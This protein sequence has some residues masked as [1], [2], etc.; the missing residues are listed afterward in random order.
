MILRS[1]VNNMSNFGGVFQEVR[2]MFIKFKFSSLLLTQMIICHHTL[3]SEWLAN[4]KQKDKRASYAENVSFTK[5]FNPY[6]LLNIFL[7]FIKEK[8]FFQNCTMV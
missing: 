1:Q 8:L 7:N 5:T 3:S 4:A 6:A 2:E